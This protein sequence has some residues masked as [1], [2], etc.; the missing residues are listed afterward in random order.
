MKP[1]QKAAREAISR[2]GNTD[3]LA[4]Q[5]AAA[6]CAIRA[7]IAAHPEPEKVR[8][9][10]DQLIGQLMATLALAHDPD[11]NLVLRDLTETLFRPPASLDTED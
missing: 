8:A 2:M 9:V 3:A 1:E 10:Y 6:Q 11:K 7:L 4:T 5:I